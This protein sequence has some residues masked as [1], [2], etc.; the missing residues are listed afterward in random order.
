MRASAE[1]LALAPPPLESLQQ[2]RQKRGIAVLRPSPCSTQIFNSFSNQRHTGTVRENFHKH[3]DLTNQ[4]K[5]KI[6]KHLTIFSVMLKFHKYPEE[7]RLDKKY[8]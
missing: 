4:I 3:P 7:K 2:L 8:Q 1:A 5:L 6:S